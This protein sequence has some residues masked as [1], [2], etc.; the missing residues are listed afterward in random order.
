MVNRVEAALTGAL[1]VLAIS[2]IVF[3][4]DLVAK[5]KM[6]FGRSLS[7]MEP[8]MFPLMAMVLMAILSGIYLW[9]LLRGS[10]EDPVRTQTSLHNAIRLAIFFSILVIYALIFEPFGFLASTFIVMAMIS[11]LAGNRSIW[12]ITALSLLGPMTIYIA[13]TR[14]LKVS[15]PELSAVEFA[16]AA[17]L[18]R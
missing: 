17:V 10:D 4:D 12:Q 11:I 3:M 13:A 6:L 2:F 8:S 15:L 7:A 5:P 9:T 1:F 14:L 18:G 16:Y